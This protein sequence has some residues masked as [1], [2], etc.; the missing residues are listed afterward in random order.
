MPARDAYG[1]VPVRPNALQMWW[2]ARRDNHLYGSSVMNEGLQKRQKIERDYH[3]AKYEVGGDSETDAHESAAYAFFN[4]LIEQLE[5]GTILD[6][7]CGDGWL[8]IR[9]AKKG[10]QAYG[11]DISRVLVEKATKWAYE[12]GLAERA[13]FEEMAGE[14]LRFPENFFDAIIG[15][16]ILHHTEFEMS[17]EG[18]YRVLKRGG[19][20]LFIEPMNQNL[21]LKLWRLLTPWRRSPA[22]KALSMSDIATVSRIFPKAR[23]HYFTFSSIFSEGLLIFFPKSRFVRAINRALERLDRFVLARFPR[24]GSSCAV[25]VM[26]LVKD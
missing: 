1:D 26:E 24:L 18:L 7:G 19:K 4:G 23:L 3:N 12:Q 10:H 6:F 17:V 22:E 13:H 8:S 15:S 20:G 9:L 21:L 2:N 16:A 14:N 11:I 5:T 25:V